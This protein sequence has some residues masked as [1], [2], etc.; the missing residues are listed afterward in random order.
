[1]LAG[2]WSSALQRLDPDHRVVIT[3][4]YFNGRSGREVAELLALPEGTVRQSRVLRSAVVAPHDGR[5]G[6][7]SVNEVRC[8]K[9]ARSRWPCTSLAIFRG[10]KRSVSSRT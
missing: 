10:K 6:V 1:M 2:R 7:G 4:L 5:G 9:L 3:E 8:E